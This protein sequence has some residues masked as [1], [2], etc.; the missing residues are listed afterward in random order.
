M[1]TSFLASFSLLLALCT[2][3]CSSSSDDTSTPVESGGS[4]GSATAGTGGTNSGGTNSGGTNSGGTNSG[5]SAAGTGGQAA[6]GGTSADADK[7]C[8]DQVKARCAR[9]DACSKDGVALKYG[10][11]AACEER[12]KIACLAGLAAPGTSST[13]TYVEGCA[14][15]IAAQSCGDF[16]N[17]AAACVPAPGPRKNGDPCGAAAQCDSTFCAVVKNT[18]CGTCAPL[19]KAG[20]SCA[21]T[22]CGRDLKC[23]GTSMICYAPGAAGAACSKDAPC[24]NGLS[25]VGAKGTGTCMAEIT[26]AGAAC[27]FKKATA[28]DC[29]RDAGLF[30]DNNNVCGTLTEGKLGDACGFDK[31]TNTS[32]ICSGSS[33]CLAPMTGA[34]KVCTAPA[35]DGAAC[36][37]ATGPFCQTPA[38]CIA[39]AAGSTA[40]TC[41]LPDP[42][43]CQ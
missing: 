21:T 40:G 20:D 35:A 15:S 10:S 30:C 27:D 43:A 17:G 22:G 18:Q 42:A 23:D 36:D 12:E 25:C 2:A 28:A 39:T 9:T 34:A 24:G 41:Q 11:E 14:A 19:P 16:L 7:A 5:G 29:D 26:Q 6:G 8:T 3:A 37:S 33:F 32:T 4:G 38:R 31:T 13:P 1:R